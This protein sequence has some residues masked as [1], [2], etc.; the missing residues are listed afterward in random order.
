MKIDKTYLAIIV[1]VIVA[2]CI[3]I[4]NNFKTNNL[5]SLDQKYV[6]GQVRKVEYPAK[7]GPSITLEY[8]YQENNYSVWSKIGE[9]EAEKNDKF[10]VLIPKGHE[11]EG[12]ILFDHP[13][14]D[15]IEAPPNGWDEVPDF[16]KK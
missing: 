16:T 5:L 3:G 11:N 2:A 9:Y 4:Y 14:P 10:L 13:V 6:V 1:F 7:G 15:E 12:I 8:R